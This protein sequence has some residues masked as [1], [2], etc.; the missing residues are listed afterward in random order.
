MSIYYFIT[1]FV[2][3]N[4]QTSVAPAINMIKGDGIYA[5]D[6]IC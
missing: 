2:I 5:R 6:M 3:S 4:G 1:Q